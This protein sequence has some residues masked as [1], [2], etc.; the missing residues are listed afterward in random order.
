VNEESLKHFFAESLDAG[1]EY[2]CELPL[3]L[4]RGFLDDLVNNHLISTP[5]KDGLSQA[6]YIY[7]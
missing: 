2:V 6:N 7:Y 4:G 5:I 1:F 3:P